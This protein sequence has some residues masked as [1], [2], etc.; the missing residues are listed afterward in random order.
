MNRQRLPFS[1]ALL[2]FLVPGL[3]LAFIGCDGGSTETD[4]GTI[5][6]QV[7]GET[8]TGNAALADAQVSVVPLSISAT[9][10]NTDTITDADGAFELA[11]LPPGGYGL[12]VNRTGYE[13]AYELVEVREGEVSEEILRLR[14]ATGP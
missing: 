4:Y 14:R 1:L 9:P 6:G 12:E 5:R 7:L 13:A 2:A 3:S 10:E 11:D 8:E